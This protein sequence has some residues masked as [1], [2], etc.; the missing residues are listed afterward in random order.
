MKKSNIILLSALIVVLLSITISMI[1]FKS[2]LYEEVEKGD[3]DIQKEMRYVSP[4]NRLN[5]TGNLTVHFTQDTVVE[6]FVEADSN[7]LEHIKTEVEDGVMK[8]SHSRGIQA[9][10]LKIHISREQLEDI[11]LSGGGRFIT[12]KP[13]QFDAINL[14]A[15]GGARL[16]MDGVFELMNMELNAGSLAKL[17]GECK[18]FIVSAMAGSNLKSKGFIAQDVTVNAVAGSNLE[19]H[20]AKTLS[21]NG[22]TG[23]NIYYHGNPELKSI[24]TGTGANLKKR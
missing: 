9:R 12:V 4:F 15:N 1:Y 2:A 24:Q 13:V 17:S 20:A 19:I 14:T 23:S 11:R 10:N 7:L 8:I 21:V 16:E 3:G 6:V 22:S 5:V 18:E